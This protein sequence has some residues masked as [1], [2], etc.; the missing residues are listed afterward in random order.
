MIRTV[1]D[2]KRKFSQELS[3]MDFPS[4]KTLWTRRIDDLGKLRVMGP[5]VCVM[6]TKLVQVFDFD[7]GK[8]MG[9][10]NVTQAMMLLY[11]N[12]NN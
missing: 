11:M 7:T 8:K 2:D 3:A 5:S 9:V 12:R 1:W 6:G 4:R 10:V